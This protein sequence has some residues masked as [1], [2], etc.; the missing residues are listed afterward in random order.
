MMVIV[1]GVRF[2]FSLDRIRKT[3][4]SKADFMSEMHKIHEGRAPKA[5][6][7]KVLDK[8]WSTAFPGAENDKEEGAE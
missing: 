3:Y 5:K 7:K 1:D 4:K 8:V 6:I 2:S